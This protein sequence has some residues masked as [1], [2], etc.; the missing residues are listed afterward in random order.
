MGPNTAQS[1]GISS[2]AEFFNI[3]SNTLYS[4]KILAVVREILCN[5]WDAH[6]ASGRTDVPVIITLDNEALIIRDRGTGIKKALMHT[7]YCVY[8]DSTKLHDGFQTGGFGLGSKA[9]FAY[10]DHFGVTNFNEGVKTIYRISKSSGEVGGRPG[11]TEIVS[12]PTD[13]T[14]IE[15]RVEMKEP[16]DV[17]KFSAAIHRIVAAGEMN[18]I[19]NGKQLETLSFSEAKEGFLITSRHVIS[20]E[21]SDRILVR[22]GNVVY[23]VPEEEVYRKPF[24]EALALLTKLKP[25][26][27]YGG[28][29]L[30][31]RLILQSEPNTISVTP[32]RESLSMS[33][34]TINTLT[35][36]LTNFVE[37]RNRR[38]LCETQ[39]INKEQISETF[40][41]LKPVSVLETSKRAIY[42]R[43][44][45]SLRSSSLTD[46]GVIS[47]QVLFNHYPEGAQFRREDITLRLKSLAES[48][49][50]N[51]G[52]IQTFLAAYNE[53][54]TKDYGETDWFHRRLVGPL[55]VKL[56]AHQDLMAN[57]LM[58]YGPNQADRKKQRRN[59]N[60]IE[61]TE[62]TKFAKTNIESYLPFLR[63]LI[64]LTYNRSA[65]EERASHLPMMKNW[66]GSVQDNLV[67]VVQRSE[68]KVRAARAFFEQQ[69]FTVLDLTKIHKSENIVTTAKESRD[70]KPRKKGIPVLTSLLNANGNINTSLSKA[71][72]AALIEKPEFV[73][74]IAARNS[75]NCFDELP[76]DISLDVVKLFGT[77]GGI[78]VNG[79]QAAKYKEQGA[80]TVWDWLFEKVFAEMKTNTSL[81]QYITRDRTRKSKGFVVHYNSA[82]VLDVI[83]RD[84]VLRVFYD[85]DTP[86]SDDER[87][88]ARIWSFLVS[89][90]SAS[91]F[92]GR[93]D[94]KVES[95]LEQHPVSENLVKLNTAIARSVLLGVISLYDLKNILFRSSST[96]EENIL[97][98]RARDLLIFSIAR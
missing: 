65:V 69:G 98:T 49:F 18:V 74:K 33:D 20:P 7:V 52:K 30:T 4:D 58:V 25:I 3:L 63:N 89:K 57:R 88:Y 40:L 29:G 73:V 10:G 1:F 96:P 9:P 80:Q 5:A 28:D 54:R 17:R 26:H 97:K 42:I 77:K 11:M 37:L 94:K 83:Y 93:K 79:T 91:R 60:E 87:R 66:F 12:L 47:R 32:S 16:G 61:F 84:P 64:I 76:D 41:G 90:M 78:V 6:I 48:G 27:Y 82:G 14:G 71:E 86:L 8:G 51:R 85:L 35:E 2:S 55:A 62:A 43:D 75:T 72:D 36:L 13:E 24:R 68:P 15:V 59:Y 39:R 31:W 56:N 50:G 23:P 95:F 70:Y 44:K 22:Y 19:M 92:S 45:D 67:Y 53:P 38:M 81:Q 21:S 34:K 46:F